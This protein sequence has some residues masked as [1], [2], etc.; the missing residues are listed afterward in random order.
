MSNFTIGA[1]TRGWFIEHAAG[2][3]RFRGFNSTGGN[4]FY[5]LYSYVPPLNTWIH[6]TFVHKNN[7]NRVYANGAL[8][9]FDNV[10]STH[11]AYDTPNYPLIGANQYNATTYQEFF[12]GKLD[13][14]SVWNRALTASDV[15]DLYNAG[16]GKQY[17]N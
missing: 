17:P 5:I 9:T 3:L 7:D 8:L 6:Y 2:Q 13:A 4:A 14:V 16:T 10:G 11:V 1:S 12:L 15:T